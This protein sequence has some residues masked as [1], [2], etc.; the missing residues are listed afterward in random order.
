MGVALVI[1]L[2][3]IFRYKKSIRKQE[4]RQR[5]L[6]ERSNNKTLTWKNLL[7]DNLDFIIKFKPKLLLFNGNPWYV[8]LKEYHKHDVFM[9]VDNLQ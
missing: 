5:T 4:I 3:Q 8:L 7:R 9:W 6:L 1:C 2:V